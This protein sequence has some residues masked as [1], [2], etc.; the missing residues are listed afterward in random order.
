MKFPRNKTVKM[1]G[2]IISVG[3]IFILLFTLADRFYPAELEKITNRLGL[4]QIDPFQTSQ[5]YRERLGI[6]LIKL[7]S[8]DEKKLHSMIEEVIKT[9]FYSYNTKKEDGLEAVKNLFLPEEYE[10]L[11]KGMEQAIEYQPELKKECDTFKNCNIYNDIANLPEIKFSQPRKYRDL[12]D[13][14]GIMSLMDIV[15]P[16]LF[17]QGSVASQYYIFIFRQVDSGWEIEKIQSLGGGTPPAEIGESN[18]IDKLLE[19]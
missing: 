9:S 18:A 1:I 10:R 14:V 6:D 11:K 13:R 15:S 4:S 2:V 19:K 12:K 3:I 5:E 17:G 16:N 8:E 7:S